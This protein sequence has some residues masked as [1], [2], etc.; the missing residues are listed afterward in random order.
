VLLFRARRDIEAGEELGFYYGKAYF[1]AAEI[2]CGCIAREGLHV[3]GPAPV[4]KI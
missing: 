2:F 3:P 1:K 4:P